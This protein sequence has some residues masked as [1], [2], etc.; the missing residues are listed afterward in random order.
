MALESGVCTSGNHPVA[1]E[2]PIKMAVKWAA[3]LH[4]LVTMATGKRQPMITQI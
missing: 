1:A 4:A 3:A 2:Q